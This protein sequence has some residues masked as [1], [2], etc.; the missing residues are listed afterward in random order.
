MAYVRVLPDAKV[1]TQIDGGGL[2]CVAPLRFFA[3]FCSGPRPPVAPVPYGGTCA[4]VCPP[5]SAGPAGPQ[6]GGY[7]CPGGCTELI[8]A[9]PL[10]FKI[11]M[12]IC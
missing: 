6:A 11:F 4:P 1:D 3:V 7:P 9:R 10:M 5:R 12:Y 8:F 2:V